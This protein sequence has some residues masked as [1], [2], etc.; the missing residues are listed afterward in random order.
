VSSYPVLYVDQ[1][2]RVA[3]DGRGAPLL[4]DLERLKAEGLTSGMVAIR[5]SHQLIQPIQDRVHPAF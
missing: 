2:A 3:R 4:D 1:P 5:F